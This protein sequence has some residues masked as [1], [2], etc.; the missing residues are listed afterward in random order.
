M[1]G[2]L[3][4][5]LA[6]AGLREE[7]LTQVESNLQHAEDRALVEGKVGDAYRALGDLPAAEAY[8]RRS[9]AEA[10]TGSDR[11]AALLRV[12]TCLVDQGREADAEAMLKAARALAAEAEAQ[13]NPPAVGRN[14]PCP[15]GSGKKYK[16]CHG[17]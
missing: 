5:A 7:A 6:R 12:V 3:A 16:K 13:A 10:I 17:S 14:E 4:I 2:D 15:C 8:Y 9:L 11:S 1:E